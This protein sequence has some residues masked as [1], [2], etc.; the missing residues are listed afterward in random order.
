MFALIQRINQDGL[1]ILLVEQNVVQ[2][3]AI[4]DRGYVLENGAIALAGRASE[5][6]DNPGLKRSY[7]GI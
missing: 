7:L 1:S 5:L 3:L 4:A 2:S 6:V